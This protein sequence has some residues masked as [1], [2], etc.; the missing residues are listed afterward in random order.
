M[1]LFWDLTLKICLFQLFTFMQSIQSSERGSLVFRAVL[2]Y[3]GLLFIFVAL[4]IKFVVSALI[5]QQIIM[6]CWGLGLT[7]CGLLVPSFHCYIVLVVTWGLGLWYMHGSYLGAWG[8]YVGLEVQLE[9]TCMC[10][11]ICLALEGNYTARAYTR[12]ILDSE[13]WYCLFLDAIHVKF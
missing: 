7:V 4:T 2:A 6:I 3:N 11:S 9:H 5:A 8:K 1:L 13:K 10:M 12:I